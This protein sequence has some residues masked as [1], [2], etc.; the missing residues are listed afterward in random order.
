M[1]DRTEGMDALIR[2]ASTLLTF[3]LPQSEVMDVM[4]DDSCLDAE[5]AWLAVVAGS[6]LNRPWKSRGAART[7]GG[8]TDP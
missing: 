1:T 7:E 2:R 6:V 4:L 3:G 8:G 5:S